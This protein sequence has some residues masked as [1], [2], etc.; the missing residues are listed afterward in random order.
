MTSVDFP[1]PVLPII[2]V[3]SPGFAVNVISCKNIFIRSRIS[4]RH[5]VKCQHTLLS[6]LQI[7]S[8]VFG[9]W[10]TVL[11]DRTSSTRS[12]ATA[13]LGSIIDNH[14]YHKE[15]HNNLHRILDKRHHISNLHLSVVD[16]FCTGPHDQN[17]DPVHNKHH[18]RHH[19]RHRAIYEQI[20]FR[21]I[22][23]CCCQTA[24]LHAS[25]Y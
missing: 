18:D 23:I 13:A 19:K 6:F 12:A 9:S 4:E 17:R 24:F 14:A 7:F 25:L 10:I 5:M 16:S 22:H 11:L 8:A 20:C 1:L 21:Q 15:S 3:V 2:A